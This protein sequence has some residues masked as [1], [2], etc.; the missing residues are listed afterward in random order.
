[1][2][3][4]VLRGVMGSAML[5]GMGLAAIG[6]AAGQA[7][8][9]VPKLDLN[10]F[11]GTWFEIVRLPNK[12]EKHCVSDAM[13]LYALGDKPTQ[14]QVVNSCTIKN[15]ST[16]SRNATGKMIGKLGDGRVR[17][18]YLWPFS[19]KYW[20]LATG[21]EY[22]WALVGSPNHKA[23]WVLSKTAAMKPEVLDEIEAKAAAE[24][25][26]RSKLIT[27]LQRHRR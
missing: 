18:T 4:Q 14:F 21:P 16:D 20:V 12:L 26:N 11:V 24:G 23:L 19:A 25:Y 9:P 27:V 13:V 17:V 5:L 3:K 22:E 1:M 10:R 8:T 15:G 6:S 7:V 2:R